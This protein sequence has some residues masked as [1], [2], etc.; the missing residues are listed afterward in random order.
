[1]NT[2]RRGKLDNGNVEFVYSA[3]F[4]QLAI[5]NIF[6]LSFFSIPFRNKLYKHDESKDK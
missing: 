2:K 6:F 3:T 4:E 1:M 5:F